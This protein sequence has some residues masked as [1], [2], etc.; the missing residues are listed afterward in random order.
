MTRVVY[1]RHRESEELIAVFDTG[2]NWDKFLDSYMF[3]GQHSPVA[4]EF[5][6][7]DC[8]LVLGTPE[9]QHGNLEK[10]LKEVVGYD[11]LY[12]D[13]LWIMKEL[14]QIEFSYL[15]AILEHRSPFSVEEEIEDSKFNLDY[16]M[17]SDDAGEV[18]LRIELG[19]LNEEELKFIEDELLGRKIPYNTSYVIFY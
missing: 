15:N 4:R 14:K 13:N 10:H 11:D 19:D 12:R 2:P 17:W 1:F 18:E 16:Q 3:V 8:D 7:E 6:I 9:D 5:L